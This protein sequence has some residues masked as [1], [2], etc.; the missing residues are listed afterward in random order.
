MKVLWTKTTRDGTGAS[1]MT[2]AKLVSSS[3]DGEEKKAIG[4]ILSV[5][6]V[7]RQFAKNP[8]LP[9]DDQS[10]IVA[11]MEFDFVY[12]NVTK[13]SFHKIERSSFCFKFCLFY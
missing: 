10:T 2:Q 5:Q 4:W 9:V 13:K 6:Q 12:L 11:N 1:Q 8:Q 7:P 3:V